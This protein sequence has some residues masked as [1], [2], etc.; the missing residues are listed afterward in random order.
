MGCWRIFGLIGSR[1]RSTHCREFLYMK[2]CRPAYFVRTT[3][4]KLD[5][6]IA[7]VKGHPGALYRF[8][9]YCWTCSFV[10]TSLILTVLFNRLA[11]IH[12]I[13]MPLL[14]LYLDLKTGAVK[15]QSFAYQ[16]HIRSSLIVIF[17]CNINISFTSFARINWNS[18]YC[19]AS[20]NVM[21]GSKDWSRKEAFFCVPELYRGSSI[22]HQNHQSC[23]Y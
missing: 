21:V 22:Y 15:G 18:W 20:T 4:S 1:L 11:I 12:D 17:D 2:L 9:I 16:N 19:F 23:L 13:A 7:V 14:L 10:V 8:V 5:L 3:Q 6:K